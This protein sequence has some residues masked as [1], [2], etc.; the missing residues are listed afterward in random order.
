MQRTVAIAALVRPSSAVACYGEWIG[1]MSGG[2]PFALFCLLDFPD[3][4][5]KYSIIAT[6]V[7]ENDYKK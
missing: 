1:D 3:A 5:G 7:P 2:D 6:M 4:W